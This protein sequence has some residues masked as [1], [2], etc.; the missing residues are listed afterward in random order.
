MGLLTDEDSK[1][2]RT[3]F[4]EMAKLVGWKVGYQY[5]LGD[6]KTIHSEPNMPMSNPMQLDIIFMENPTQD[7]LKKHGWTVEIGEQKPV[8]AQVPYDTP[9]LQRYSRFIIPPVGTIVDSRVFE[10]TA[11]SSI[12]EYPDCWTV[13]LAP[14]YKT[15]QED[16]DY[17]NLNIDK[18][19]VT[20]K[21]TL[22]S[23]NEPRINE[24]A[25]YEFPDVPIN[26]DL[27]ELDEKTRGSKIIEPKET[28]QE[29]NPK[30][31]YNNNILNKNFD[32]FG[33]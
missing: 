30:N 29:E 22:D 11:I 13:R 32:D 4:C 26:K 9:N 33:S 24:Q 6:Q 18:M 1:Q 20:S 5:P 27:E 2:F 31:N 23:P 14:V 10:V 8:V 3:W 17:T 25:H 12:L 16:N 15:I 21:G 28:K 19:D 7:T